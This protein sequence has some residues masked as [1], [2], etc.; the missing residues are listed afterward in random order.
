LLRTHKYD[1][2]LLIYENTSPS[3]DLLW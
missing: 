3:R 2:I 1:E